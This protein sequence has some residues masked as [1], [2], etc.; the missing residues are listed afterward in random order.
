MGSAWEAEGARGLAAHAMSGAARG[1][2]WGRSLA[3]CAG[4]V[5]RWRPGSDV[6]A[7]VQFY[8]SIHFRTESNDYS[9]KFVAGHSSIMLFADRQYLMLYLLE[10]T[11]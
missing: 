6:R 2:C 11:L 3:C 4:T 7:Q 8:N 5:G 9:T 1:R 10:N